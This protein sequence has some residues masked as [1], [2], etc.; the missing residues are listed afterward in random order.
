MFPHSVTRPA[1]QGHENGFDRR[2]VLGTLATV[3]LVAALG[4]SARAAPDGVIS[5]VGVALNDTTF[6]EEAGEFVTVL[7]LLHVQT[8]A[9]ADGSVDLQANLTDQVLAYSAEVQNPTTERRQRLLALRQ[10]AVELV[11]QIEALELELAMLR[12]ALDLEIN[13]FVR[14]RL[15]D[16]IARAERRLV[17]LYKELERVQ[18]AMRALLEEIGEEE[19]REPGPLYSLAGVQRTRITCA[20][21]ISCSAYLVF[22]LAHASQGGANLAVR[23]DLIFSSR[24]L[25]ISSAADIGNE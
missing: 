16:L 19:G 13:P 25:L 17:E 9:L 23:L 14:K 24:G 8:K 10:Q 12:E 4:F 1:P 2:P 20:P 21:A 7:G 22:P 6:I 3:G 5:N 11:N 18:A 15:A